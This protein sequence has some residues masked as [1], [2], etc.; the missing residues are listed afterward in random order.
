T[1][2]VEE[3]EARY[4]GRA[5]AIADQLGGRDL[6][7]GQVERIE[8]AGGSDDGGPVLIIVED[9]DVHEFAQTLLDHETFRCLD[10]FEVDAAPAFAAELYAMEDVGGVVGG[11]LEID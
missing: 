10:V 6:A 8:Q 7:A 11:K 1:D 5:R 3:L 2:R 4:P 9:R